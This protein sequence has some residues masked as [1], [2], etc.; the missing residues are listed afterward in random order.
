M[1]EPANRQRAEKAA[2]IAKKEA[3]KISAALAS[4]S[5]AAEAGPSRRAKA[6]ES[7]LGTDGNIDYSRA[8]LVIP[9]EGMKVVV[10]V[11]DNKW[12]V[13]LISRDN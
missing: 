8:P 13:Q 7:A 5:S 9:P 3:D 1:E 4:T 2:E 11:K 6:G 10:S 12:D